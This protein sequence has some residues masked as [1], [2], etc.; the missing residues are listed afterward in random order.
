MY[1]CTPFHPLLLLY[2][3][4]A[5]EFQVLA[6]LAAMRW[7]DLRYSWGW[8][9]AP[10]H[11]IVVFTKSRCGKGN[12]HQGGRRAYLRRDVKNGR[13]AWLTHAVRE[14]LC[15]DGQSNTPSHPSVPRG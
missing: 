8:L 13:T 6:S 12:L 10:M 9:R 7:E 15:R 1:M 2:C 3:S 11:E 4:F 14:I 5:T